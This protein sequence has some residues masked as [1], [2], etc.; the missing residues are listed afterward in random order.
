MFFT[1]FWFYLL[2]LL[3]ARGRFS[4]YVRV[5]FGYYDCRDKIVAWHLAE[6]EKLDLSFRL[7]RMKR[8]LDGSHGQ[9]REAEVSPSSSSYPRFFDSQPPP[10]LRSKEEIE[11]RIQEKIK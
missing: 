7:R 11:K 10:H 8:Q 6:I 5:V 4:R 9:T 1:R 3:S 2:G